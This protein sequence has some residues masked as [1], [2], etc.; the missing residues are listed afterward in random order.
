[1]V[2][3]A[4]ASLALIVGG[5]G[6]H[7]NPTRSAAAAEQAKTLT[8]SSTT[9]FRAPGHARETSRE[10]GAINLAEPAYRVR[11]FDLRGQVAFER[12]VFPRALYVRPLRSRRP[13]RWVAAELCPRAV[14]A[15]TARGSNGV[16]DILGLLEVLRHTTSRRI[17]EE[18]S[19]G[20]SVVHYRVTTTLG[21]Y[22]G[23]IGQPA[24]PPLAAGGVVIN[25]WID[26]ENR[27]RRAVRRFTILGSP[28]S[29]LE[30]RTR[31]GD[32]GRPIT[33]TTP[34]GVPHVGSEPLDPFANDP[35]TE[36]VLRAVEAHNPRSGPAR[37]LACTRR[38]P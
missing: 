29:T 14:I 11:I 35:V 36:N 26:S 28:A 32:Y 1:M 15:P 22:L 37:L 25:V 12:R 33:I 16:A 20:I 31:F 10:E 30:I 23:A 38:A 3:L 27:V 18:E 9:V 34:P 24:P 2:V 21:R 13:S 8:F 7:A 6:V 5:G 17:G 19:G 4:V